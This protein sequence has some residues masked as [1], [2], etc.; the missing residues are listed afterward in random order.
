MEA[1]ERQFGDMPNSN[2]MQCLMLLT[3][4]TEIESV[5]NIYQLLHSVGRYKKTTHT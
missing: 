4:E 2:L 1:Y 5:V 3:H